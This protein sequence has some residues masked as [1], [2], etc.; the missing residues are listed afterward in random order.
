[1]TPWSSAGGNLATSICGPVYL[2]PRLPTLIKPRLLI[3]GWPYGAHRPFVTPDR[4]HLLGWTRVCTARQYPMRSGLQSGLRWRLPH[5]PTILWTLP[6]RGLHRGG[7][8]DLC[9]SRLRFQ[10]LQLALLF[11]NSKVSKKIILHCRAR[12]YPP[13]ASR[14]RGP[15]GGVG[16]R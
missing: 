6:L 7:R 5:L 8:Q 3:S 1:L 2:M 14:L 11:P 12:G 15:G 10:S 9:A 13:S 16:F 4:I